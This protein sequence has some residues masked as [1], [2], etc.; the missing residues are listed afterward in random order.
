MLRRDVELGRIDICGEVSMMA[1]FSD[2]PNVGRLEG[3]YYMFAYLKSH[4][5]SGVIFDNS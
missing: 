5:R 1:A 3:L 4:K 2:M